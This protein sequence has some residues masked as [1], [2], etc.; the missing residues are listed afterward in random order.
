ME[1]LVNP[2]ILDTTSFSTLQRRTGKTHRK[3]CQ[4]STAAEGSKTIMESPG[5]GAPRLVQHDDVAPMPGLR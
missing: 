1:P 4:T 3:Q 5:T 2:F